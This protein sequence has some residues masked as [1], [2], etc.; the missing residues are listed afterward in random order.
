[1]C[2]CAA[3]TTAGNLPFQDW[4]PRLDRQGLLLSHVLLWQVFSHGPSFTLQTVLGKRGEGT[5]QG[6]KQRGQRCAETGGPRCHG[7]ACSRPPL[8]TLWDRALPCPRPAMLLPTPPWERFPS[9]FLRINPPSTAPNLLQSSLA[10]PCPPSQE[11]HPMF[12]T[13]MMYT[14]TREYLRGPCLSL[15]G[16][17]LAIS[18]PLLSV[19]DEKTSITF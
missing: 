2:P 1:M 3:A 16:L 14:E 8:W 15:S 7:C 10:P 13:Q 17:T 18:L 12:P 19:L 9:S 6:E 11:P 4:S 5:L